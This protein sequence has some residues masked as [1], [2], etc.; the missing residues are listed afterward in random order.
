[1]NKIQHPFDPSWQPVFSRKTLM[2]AM[3][4]HQD[5]RHLFYTLMHVSEHN[6][7]LPLA[8]HY[9]RQQL[10]DVGKLHSDNFSSDY[11]PDQ[12][13]SVLSPALDISLPQ[14]TDLD[15][16]FKQCAPLILTEPCWLQSVSQAATCQTPL[17]VKLM[18]VYLQLT[19]SQPYLHLYRAW[20][21]AA[22]Y[23]PPPLQSWAFA[24]QADI[25]GCIFDFAALQ[26]ALSCF[27]RVFF[28][29]L[30]GFTLAYC[31]VPVLTD[32][33]PTAGKLQ[34]PG[35]LGHFI[36][37]RKLSAASQLPA[38]TAAMREYLRLFTPQ[39][40]ELWQRLQTGYWLFQE[41]KQRCYRQL[42]LQSGR[43]LSPDQAFA[44]LLQG[45]AAAAFGHHGKIRLAGKSLDDWFGQ[46][47]F[48]SENFLTA[49][50]QSPYADKRNPVD[51]PL[52]KLFDFQGP[53]FGVFNEAE[54]QIVK[55]WLCAE[56]TDQQAQPLSV[57]TGTISPL[58][59]DGYEV[60]SIGL[61]RLDNRE[62]YY[63]LVNADLF[64]D[65]LS[66]AKKKVRH[67]LRLSELCSLL[68]FKR[69][70]HQAFDD[71]IANL[72]RIE[73]NA[74]EP[75]KGEPKLAKK[76][77]VWGIEQFAPTI[78]TD[79][80]W[81][82]N[83]NQA[84]AHPVISSIL[85]KIYS[86]ETGNGLL[87]QNHPYIYQQLLDS[88]NIDLPPIHSRA[89]INCPQFITGAFDIP[90]YLLAISRCSGRFLPELLGLNMAI[91]LSGLGRVY[92]R[93]AEELRFW[94]INP[95]IVKV[96]ISIDN[97]ASG[98][99]SLAKKAIQLYLDEIL[100]AYGEQEMQLQWRRIYTGYRSLQIAS[101]RFK[102]ALVVNY[103]LKGMTDRHSVT[104]ASS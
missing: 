83:I 8:H 62:L 68:P 32:Y 104:S 64:P 81:L 74:Y 39:T 78:L 57:E 79:G 61:T 73:V 70:N 58:K 69:Y 71:Y 33:F 97:L 21:L 67:I 101:S 15:N 86:D 40:K 41:H 55:T 87:D 91:E 4:Y 75:L 84:D 94:G 63:Y 99:A 66:A 98:H 6:D 16:C 90:V 7:V 59:I 76:A 77:Y 102:V 49:L 2:A 11:H 46:S 52:L 12:I 44:E 37:A 26:L 45:K 25:N 27:P 80:C 5:G 18:S 54:K 23:D 35:S 13:D 48:D 9:L 36:M 3:N 29:E 14:G 82:Q 17:A 95:S 47:P 50:R 65:V 72:Y 30:L 19:Q 43:A 100:A 10:L 22:G 1:M 88:L 96:H 85:F 31:Q 28:P 92:L 20:L 103:L 56:K 42:S 34:E 53:M 24:E 89:F 60:F 93:L 51:S 38:V